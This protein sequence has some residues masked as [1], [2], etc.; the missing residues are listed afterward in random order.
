MMRWALLRVIAVAAVMAGSVRPAVA[1]AWVFPEHT[2]EVTVVVQE[3]DH[4]GR[5]MDDGTRVPV[6]KAIN[7]GVDVE[8]DYAFTSRLSISTSL[9]YVIS[10]FTGSNPPPSWLPRAAADI[11]GCWHSEFADFGFT[12][13]YNIINVNRAFMLTPLISV[14]LPSH[15]YDYVGEAVVGRRLKELRLGA[16]AGQRLDG[17]LPGMSV[18]AGY[19]YT[20]VGRVLNVPNNRSNGS[21]RTALTFANG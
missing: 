19:A 10:K 21:V 11:C 3:I 9:P 13:R 16:D 14:G 6:G 17:L 18:Q 2:G 7:M 1:Q 12:T 5:M 4:V 8:L 20:I 15:A